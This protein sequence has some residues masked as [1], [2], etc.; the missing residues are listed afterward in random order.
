MFRYRF[1]PKPGTLAN[2]ISKKTRVEFVDLPKVFCEQTVFSAPRQLMIVVECREVIINYINKK[3]SVISA[4]LFKFL[5][6]RASRHHVSV[7]PRGVGLRPV[8]VEGCLNSLRGTFC[9]KGRAVDRNKPEPN[10]PGRR[11]NMDHL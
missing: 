8:P 6:Q 4:L 3:R 7:W 10:Q 1:A 5:L 11:G 9:A 2:F